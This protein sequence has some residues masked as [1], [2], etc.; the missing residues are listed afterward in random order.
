MKQII[1]NYKTGKLSVEEVPT[2]VLKAGGVLVQTAYS[3]ISA[4]TE[5][6][7]LNIAQKSLLGKAQS[8]PDLVQKVLRTA[9]KEGVRKTYQIVSDRL[10]VPVPLGYSL[11]GNVIEIASDVAGICVGDQVACA[12]AGYANHA[13]IV[14]VPK[15]LC[16]VVPQGVSLKHAAFSTLGSISLHAVRQASL[17]IGERVGII[18]LGLLGLLTLQLCK[19]SGCSVLGIDLEKE[20]VQSAMEMGADL[21]ISRNDPDLEDKIIH[22]T[23]GRG[24]DRVIVAAGTESKDPFI[25]SGEIL[26]DRGLLV[27]LGGVRMELVRTISSR[28]YRKEIEIRLARSYGPGRYDP[29][30]EEKGIDY[31]F[32]YVRW[33]EQRNLAFFLELVAKETVHLDSLT[34]HVFQV[35]DAEKAYELIQRGTERSI[36]VLLAYPGVVF[37]EPKKTP[38]QRLVPHTKKRERILLGMIGAGNFA[39][40]NL[41]PS[42]T[43]DKRVHLHS[44]MTS[45]GLSAERTARRFGFHQCNDSAEEIV[46]DPECDLVLIATRH[47]SHAHYARMGLDQGKITYVEK[48]LAVTRNQLHEMWNAVHRSSGSLVVGYNRRFAPLVK[49][50]KEFFTNL[51]APMTILYRVNAGHIPQDHWY[52]DTEQGGRIVGEGCH[53]V[54]LCQFLTGSEPCRVYCCGVEDR[55]KIIQ[56]Q[57]NVTLS[58]RFTNGSLGIVH[59]LSQGDPRMPKERVEVFGGN[60]CAV[61]DDFR[62]LTLYRHGKQKVHRRSRMDKGY[63]Q[64]MESLIQFALGGR[65]QPIT[66][67]SLFFT[68]LTT[69]CAVDS[70]RTGIPQTISFSSLDVED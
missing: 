5:R 4:G 48:P 54:D 28:F 7:T 13:E 27:L 36:G 23:K 35:E 69:F 26:R 30:Y 43:R 15:N 64:E 68:S 60:T 70:L 33:T 21:A 9:Q 16:A 65:P 34:T 67:E 20:P 49:T 53:F 46:S 52:Q 17:S 25:L 63:N 55:E 39:R 1:Q 22:F 37:E 40:S 2:P 62:T 44:L 32:G 50:L 19:S 56:N 10:N 51:S 24:L 61:L 59:Y 3:L 11:A 31:P 66:V 42:L 29:A 58:I 38:E 45:T 12:G 57:D 18:G 8:R 14:F 6:D 47:D 41:L